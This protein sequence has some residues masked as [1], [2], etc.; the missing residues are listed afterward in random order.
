MVLSF[1]PNSKSVSQVY[2]K[3]KFDSSS[4]DGGVVGQKGIQVTLHHVKTSI[5]G[6]DEKAGGEGG[7]GTT[8]VIREG[9]W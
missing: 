9:A 2:T 4:Y 5:R 3:K 6:S 7:E 1:T 8:K